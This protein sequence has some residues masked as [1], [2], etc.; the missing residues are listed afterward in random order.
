M[1]VKE[2]FKFP[3]ER[4]IESVVKVNDED[5]EKVR[6][7]MEEYV[8]TN[9]LEI[10]YD[11]I[12]EKILDSKEQ[13]TRD[14]GV[15]LS[16]FFGSGKSLFM[17]NLSYIL[18]GKKIGSKT[19]S[20]IFLTKL[21]NSMTKANLSTING[22]MKIRP[23]L[24]EIKSQEDQM[25][26]DSIVEILYRQFNKSF[27]FSEQVWI[28][29]LEKELIDANKYE[30]FKNEI[31]KETNMEWIDF[32]TKTLRLKPVLYKTLKNIYPGVYDTDEKIKESIASF[33]K[34][35]LTPEKFAEKIKE[36]VD[37]NLSAKE[38]LIFFIDEMGMFV[39]DNSE[40]L[41]ELQS[42]V[43]NVGVKSNGKI[44]IVVTAQEKL[45]EVIEGVKRKKVE[46]AKIS[47]RFN[48]RI[49]LTS[50]NIDMVV[51]ERI[52]KKKDSAIKE[53]TDK[54]HKIAG[55]INNDINFRDWARAK[56]IPK[57]DDKSFVETYPFLPY[58]LKVIPEIFNNIRS[59]G[60]GYTK[61]SGR[62]RSM[63]GAV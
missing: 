4:K 59:K 10:H 38:K 55:K 6:Q 19:A 24:F 36:F 20:E 14:I 33:E 39:G 18:E 16:G 45:D 47:D 53:L 42:I 31:K 13:P 40:K 17:K 7:E 48:M 9:A 52:L 60:A 1:K 8:V 22:S 43:E 56:L 58:Q 51:K 62:E 50:E 15:W 2:L 32:R 26:P 46:F 61:L 34:I 29:E 49:T 35:S 25:N 3:I 54:Y 5:A 27:G 63:L 44:W 21:E 11:N 57:L 41:L 37:K 23:I 12:L 30:E 28:A